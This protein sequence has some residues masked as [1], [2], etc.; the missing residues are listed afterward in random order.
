MSKTLPK[1]YEPQ[2]IEG[3]IYKRWEESGFF[4]PD[5]LENTDGK[6][7]NVL[8]PPNA[9]GE[10]HLGHSSGYTVMDIFGRW[11]RMNGKKTLLLP[12]KDHAGIQSQVV[13]EKKIQQEENI[14]RHDLG[15]DEFY[16]R[17]Y[18]FCIDRADYMRSQEKRLGI[19]A[20]WSRE[21][22]TMDPDVLKNALETF[23]KMHEDGLVYKGKRIIN[24]CP[25][26]ASALS[27]VEVIHKETT[28]KLYYIKYPLKDSSEFI[29]VATTRPETMLGDSAVAVS[30]DDERFSALVGKNVS[31]PL[32]DKTIA[33]IADKR[34]DKSFGTG[35]VKITPA[36]DPL[37][38]EI[39]KDHKLEEIQIINEEAKITE[40]GGKYSGLPVE[41]AREKIVADLDSLGLLEK[42]EDIEHSV[43]LC[44]RC[45]STIEPLISS[46]WFIDVDAKKYSLKKKAIEAIENGEIV[47]FPESLKKDLINWFTILRDWCISRQIWWGPQFPVWYCAKCGDD[48]YIVSLEKP[49]ACPHCGSTDLTQDENTFDTWFTS[50]Q[51]PYTT[52]QSHDDDYAQFYP[53]DMMVMGRDLLFFWAARMIM[54]GY[55]RTEK[56]P[57]KNLFFTGLIR[58]KEGQKMSKSKGNGIN[59]VEMID[60]FGADAMR[61]SIIMDSAPGQDSRLYEEK[62]ETFRNFANKLWNISRYCLSQDNFKLEENI[63]ESDLNSKADHWI[64]GILDEKIEEINRLFE[65]KQIAVAADT[66]KSFTW[67]VFADN[68][69]EW[70]KI[71]RN[72]KVLGYVLDKILR[73]WHPFMPFITEH[74][75]DLA[76]EEKLLMISKW[77]QPCK[78]YTDKA[79]HQF[80]NILSII[81]S[82]NNVRAEYKLEKNVKIPVYFADSKTSKSTLLNNEEFIK[83]RAGVSNI[84]F[85]VTAN[86]Q[87][88]SV[89]RLVADINFQIPMEGLIDTEKEGMKIEKEIANLEKFIAGLEGRLGNEEFV[90]KA[91][92]NIIDQ[93]T[94]SLGKA[95]LELAE[96]KKHLALLK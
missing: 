31:L 70:D 10:L 58:D 14:S 59:P 23:L 86:A 40:L 39:G 67:D 79:S 46:Q 55:Y 54:M 51:W 6:H 8:P 80:S 82:I 77:P 3:A 36:H 37:D 90:K 43:S 4:N 65:S 17:I 88:D 45:K 7:C 52:L 34:V 19:S 61:M 35:A 13:Y 75:W 50:S 64:V 41:E 2:I 56:T 68:Y 57:F 16:R 83:R 94:D 42:I 66:L 92:K 89:K 78:L 30:P 93:Q 11:A 60:R 95:R 21:K 12:G 24:W 76:G 84:E 33:I 44:E 47:V 87:Q 15:R 38:W 48:K 62:I 49:S 74:I 29:T 28:G 26:C 20:D 69:V 72:T 18:D 96:L 32:Q 53:T 5:N 22:F 9:N 25:R 81:K 73:L 63:F 85:F 1:I 71:G 27:D 91:P